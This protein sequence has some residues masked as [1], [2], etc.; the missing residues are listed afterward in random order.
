[1]T[2]Q[3]RQG[4]AFVDASTVNGSG[5]SGLKLRRN[6]AWSVLGAAGPPDPLLGVAIGD[7]FMGGFY[8]GIMDTTGG[9]VSGID[10]NPYGLRYALIVSPKSMEHAGLKWKTTISAGAAA[11]F[12]RWDGRR[13]TAENTPLSEY[14]AAVHCTSQV[15]PVDDAS[16]WYLPAMDEME[17]IYRNLKCSAEGNYV[18]ANRS[19]WAGGMGENRSSVPVGVANTSGLPAQ[20]AVT[21]F[22]SGGA[23]ALGVSGVSR[24]YWTSTD[25]TTNAAMSQCCSGASPGN[26]SSSQK[27]G[28]FAVRPVRRLPLYM[29]PPVLSPEFGITDTFTR[30]NGALAGSA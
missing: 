1:M 3:V 7:P 15:A 8:A 5:T 24:Y 12:T 14:T 25:S 23:Q 11:A 27:D 29:V 19:T 17:L 16:G 28:V 9:N 26:Q 30:A 13:S 10:T 2:C 6:A 22:R 20:T 4:G 21:A 18:N